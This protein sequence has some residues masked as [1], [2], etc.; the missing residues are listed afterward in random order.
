MTKHVFALVGAIMAF[1]ISGWLLVRAGVPSTGLLVYAFFCYLGIA[2]F[3]EPFWALRVPEPV[4]AI[5]AW[6]WRGTA[7]R[8]LRVPQFGAVLRNSPL[9]FLNP[10]VYLARTAAAPAG[11][12]RQ[13]ESAEAIHFWGIPLLLPA[14]IH[15]VRAGNWSAAGWIAALQLLGNIYP[16][17]H[18]RWVRVRLLRV[19]RSC[20][21]RSSAA[22]RRGANAIEAS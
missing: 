15:S 5:Q 21:V 18:L 1:S 19:A 9:R 3:A 12:L 6:E 8:R 14:L 22:G 17:M 20:A 4:R 7:Y 2:R 11:V 10:T 16:I 13:I